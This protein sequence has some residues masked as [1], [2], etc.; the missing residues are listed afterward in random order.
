M[1]QSTKAWTQSLRTASTA[2]SKLIRK[3]SLKDWASTVP[4]SASKNI[5]DFC[6]EALWATSIAKTRFD[7]ALTTRRTRSSTGQPSQ[8][9]PKVL[10][11]PWS[12][13]IP[14]KCQEH[15][16]RSCLA[17]RVITTIKST[18]PSSGAHTMA[19][20]KSWLCQISAS[21]SYL[22]KKTWRTPQIRQLSLLSRFH[23]RTILPIQIRQSTQWAS[24]G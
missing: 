14:L 4:I 9:P 21:R 18:C 6:T 7:K 19:R 24:F 3:H 1:G 15:F 8:V 23:I 11:R 2:R 17:N 20:K 12:S 22:L 10:S 13:E 16:S 5:I